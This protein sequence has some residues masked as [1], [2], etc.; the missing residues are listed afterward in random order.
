MMNA[1]RNY[2]VYDSLTIRNTF[3]EDGAPGQLTLDLFNT[4]RWLTEIP[5]WENPFFEQA[6][7]DTGW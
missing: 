7:M 3:T 6:R 1:A 2:P 5:R 4:L